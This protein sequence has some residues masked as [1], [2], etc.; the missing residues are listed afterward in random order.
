[1]IK[2]KEECF[3]HILRSGSLKSRS[4]RPGLPRQGKWSDSAIYQRQCPECPDCH[5]KYV[6]QRGGSF[7]QRYKEHDRDFKTGNKKSAFVKHL[8]NN[9]HVIGTIESIMSVLHGDGYY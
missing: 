6:G 8:I 2:T 5:I 3:A 9:S 7:Y 4:L 1:M